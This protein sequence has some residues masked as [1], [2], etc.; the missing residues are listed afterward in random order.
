MLFCLRA[1]HLC[2]Q[3]YTTSNTTHPYETPLLQSALHGVPSGVSAKQHVTLSGHVKTEG[4]Q[5]LGTFKGL[6]L[7]QTSHLQTSTE[8]YLQMAWHL[9]CS[10]VPVRM[11]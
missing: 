1:P 11:L 6:M 3:L 7:P 8:H 5:C 9:A 2:A 4:G 10:P